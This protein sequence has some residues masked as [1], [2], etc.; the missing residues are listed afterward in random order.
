MRGTGRTMSSARRGGFT[1]VELL[2]VVAILGVLIGLVAGVGPV[3]FANQR[4]SYAK[5][6]L[7]TLDR[8][9][10]EYIS[11]TGGAPKFVATQ[12]IGTPGTDN[13]LTNYQGQDYPAR[14]DAAVFL[15]QVRGTGAC[16]SIV[17]AL[18]GDVLKITTPGSVSTIAGVVPSVLDPWASP[19]WGPPWPVGQ[20]QLIY[21]VHPDN[22]LAQDLYGA[23]V[24]RRPYF[25]SA[26]PD[27]FYGLRREPD[28]GTPAVSV[29]EAEGRL[30]DNIYSYTPGSFKKD[31]AER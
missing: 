12:Y 28:T 21:Y 20:Q 18:P 23:C 2:V 17:S 22:K 31:L 26:G 6:V 9:L 30:A 14:P 1:L 13:Q 8:V 10:D 19:G 7:S 16:D 27:K 4:V 29:E 25:M 3:V 24:N 11:V 5:K 15:F